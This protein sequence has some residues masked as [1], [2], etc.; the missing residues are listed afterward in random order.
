[1]ASKRRRRRV[2]NAFDKPKNKKVLIATTD[3]EKILT[4]TKLIDKNEET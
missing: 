4:I 3:Y 2:R 1:M